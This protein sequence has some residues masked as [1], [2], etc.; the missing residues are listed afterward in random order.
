MLQFNC[1][2]KGV[3]NVDVAS[4]IRHYRQ[5]RG[6]TQKVL[7]EKCGINEVTIRK[8]ELGDR[9]PK[10]DQLQKI[11]DALDVSIFAFLD[12]DMNNASDAITL[13][14]KMDDFFDIH[15]SGSTD[16]NDQI[17]PSTLTIRFRDNTI[18]SRLAKYAY[19]KS[20][21]DQLKAH[22]HEYPTLEAY[23]E[24]KKSLQETLNQIKNHLI[25]TPIK[26]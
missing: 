5:A 11:A 15:F 20:L 12:I 8:Y 17:I 13:L 14:L 6:L 7:G 16:Q 18:N 9:N 3:R 23:E 25:D 10:I 22:R 19:A 21:V 24:E 2:C 1:I 26:R 4:K